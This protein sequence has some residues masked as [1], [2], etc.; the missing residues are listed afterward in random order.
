MDIYRMGTGAGLSFPEKSDTNN[1]IS[2]LILSNNLSY[3]LC[4]FTWESV[5]L[6]KS[7]SSKM[8]YVEWKIIFP[9]I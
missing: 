2:E 6:G 1:S 8:A 4:S 9:C 5:Y 3:N 7:F